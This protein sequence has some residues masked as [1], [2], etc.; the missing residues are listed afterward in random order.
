MEVIVKM[1]KTTLCVC[2]CVCATY[3]KHA[4]SDPD[5]FEIRHVIIYFFCAFTLLIKHY[6]S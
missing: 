4:V 3:C 6:G 2:V 5:R 1:V